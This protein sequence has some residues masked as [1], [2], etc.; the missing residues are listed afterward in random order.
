MSSNTNEVLAP[1]VK[2]AQ[3]STIVG[4]NRADM[5]NPSRSAAATSAPQRTFSISSQ[6]VPGLMVA[7]DSLVILSVALI[8]YSAIIGDFG[9]T[10]YYGAAIG[11]V[12][13]ASILLMNFAG[14][15]QFESIM[16]PLAVADKIAIA[17]ATTFLFLLAAAFSLKISAEY[18]RIWIV[19]F[20]IGTCAATMLFR[21]IASRILG[22]LA[23]MRVFS[24]NV[25]IIGAGE[26]ARK[27]LAHIEISRPRFV[28]VLGLFAD[29][30]HDLA[31][32]R[33]PTLGRPDELASYV[34][35][36]DVD[37]VIIS[38]PWSADDQITRLMSKLRELPV[39]VY[40]G[41]DL[42][43]FRLPL[44]Q[45]PDHFGEMPLTE[46]MGRPLAGWGVVGKAALDYGL[47]LILT[48]LL[49]PLL[50]LIAIAIKLESKGPVLF[51]QERYGFVNRV[52]HIYKFRTMIHAQVCEKKT[53]QATRNDPR[54][55]RVGRLLRRLSL[56][57]LPQLF[58][59]LGGSMSLVGPRPHAI[60]HNE[61]YS[62]MIR[63]YFA[64]HRV[65]PGLTGW[66]Q[67]NGYRGETKTLAQMEAR[68]RHDIY[69][70]ENW[71][72]LFDL[73]IL[74]KTLIICLTGRNAY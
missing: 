11:F 1:L 61:A 63:G 51:R 12:W 13:L 39:N 69:Y 52:F 56:D 40:L 55:T 29:G 43:G 44:R 47:G 46:V 53:I 22:R 64:R 5:G 24:R 35:D 23:D 21:L 26:Q 71:S 31:D 2:V 68:V 73:K 15:Y 48:V 50:M 42:V 30:P 4:D 27:L 62:Q 9:D 54:V 16:R 17:F 28:S 45:P 3:L 36:H 37:D 49:L 38:L 6:V 72:V 74:M 33:Y 70:V 57:E 60:D 19:S 67:V 14:L 20:A 32:S 65:K 7:L 10:D 41:A 18:S 34:R 8:T 66:A 59:V 58:N 25:V